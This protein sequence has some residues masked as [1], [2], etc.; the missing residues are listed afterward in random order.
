MSPSSV[1][2]CTVIKHKGNQLVKAFLLSFSWM[3]FRICG[4]QSHSGCMSS[5]YHAMVV[6]KN[7]C[8]GQGGLEDLFLVLAL[9]LNAV[10]P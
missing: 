6:T 3:F 1:I 10:W 2:R 5:G 4:Q 8:P 9:P 7:S